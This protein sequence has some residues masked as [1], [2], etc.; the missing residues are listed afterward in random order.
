M[1]VE[2]SPGVK[3]RGRMKLEK[4]NVKYGFVVCVL[5]G[6]GMHILG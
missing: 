5:R 3:G 2:M 4:D 6:I 1:A